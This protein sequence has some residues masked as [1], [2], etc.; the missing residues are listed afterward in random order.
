[1]SRAQ[2]SPGWI[3]NEAPSA[4]LPPVQRPEQQPPAIPPSPA[5]AVQG[6]PAVRQVLFSGTHVPPVQVPLQQLADVVHA[7]LSATQLEAL[8]HLLMVVSH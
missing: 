3:Q 7:A 6:L 1:V 4:H 5:V 2:T 8:A